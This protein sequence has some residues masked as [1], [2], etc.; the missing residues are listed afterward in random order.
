MNKR[1]KRYAILVI[2]DDKDYLAF[3]A[4]LLRGSGYDVDTADNGQVALSL[5]RDKAYDLILT[6]LRL[7]K[8]GVEPSD[9]VDGRKLINE[10]K[11]RIPYTQIIILSGQGRGVDMIDAINKHVYRYIEKAA[12]DNDYILRT[13]EEALRDRDPVL[14]ALENLLDKEQDETI[15]LSGEHT[16]THRQIYDEVKRGTPF[17][18]EYYKGLRDSMIGATTPQESIDDLLG[19]KGVV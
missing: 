19:I 2:E 14:L 3:L 4:K 10:I 11:D 8:A 17:G 18:K 15:V 9:L 13:I 7:P 16:P 5:W 6:D 1:N 12:E